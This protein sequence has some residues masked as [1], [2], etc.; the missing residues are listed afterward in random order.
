MF[1]SGFAV[2]NSWPIY[3]AIAWRKDK[4]KMPIKTSIIATL[5]AGTLYTVSCFVFL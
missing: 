1:I 5:L 4:G 2:V 3:E